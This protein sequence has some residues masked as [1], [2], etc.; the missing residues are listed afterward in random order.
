[1]DWETLCNFLL[2][3]RQV[4]TGLTSQVR[5]RRRYD[6]VCKVFMHTYASILPFDDNTLITPLPKILVQLR[7]P[8]SLLREC[9]SA[10]SPRG[11]SQVYRRV[12]VPKNDVTAAT[13]KIALNPFLCKSLLIHW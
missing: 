6:K 9:E 12:C 7:L 1:M 3:R 11:A 13:F 2:M 5:L 4:Q 8:N 10:E